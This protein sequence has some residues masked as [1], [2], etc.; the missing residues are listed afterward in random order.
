MLKHLEAI[1]I[2]MPATAEDEDDE[3]S[4]VLVGLLFLQH[5]KAKRNGRYGHQGADDCTKSEDFFC[6]MLEAF[7]PEQFKQFMRYS[8][9][10]QTRYTNSDTLMVRVDTGILGN[11]EADKLEGEGT[12]REIFSELDLRIKNK[13]NITGGQLSKMTQAIVYQGIKE[14]K[15]PPKPRTGTN[16]RLDITRYTVEEMFGQAPLNEAI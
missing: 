3:L 5:R 9:F 15:E 11:K 1:A 10:Y 13:F 6:L 12:L 16:S 7:T 8:S 14:N 2:Y 4:C